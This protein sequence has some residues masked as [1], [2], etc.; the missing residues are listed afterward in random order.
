MI[1]RLLVALAAALVAGVAATLA[2]S[3]ALDIH[4]DP[5]MAV[6]QAVFAVFLGQYLLLAFLLSRRS[7]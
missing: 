4:W 3:A 5:Q 7:K 6:A 2:I 1:R